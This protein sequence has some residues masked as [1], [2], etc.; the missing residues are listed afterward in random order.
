MSVIKDNDVNAKSKAN[1]L[2]AIILAAYAQTKVSS[3][4][5]KFSQIASQ[6][7]KNVNKLR[8]QLGKAEKELET[9]KNQFRG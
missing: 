7:G 1:M 5:N 2:P 3:T 6:K 9:L 8:T 4:Y